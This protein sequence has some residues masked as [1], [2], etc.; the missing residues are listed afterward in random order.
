MIEQAYLRFIKE[1]NN[2]YKIDRGEG[3]LKVINLT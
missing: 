2:L 1:E 3:V